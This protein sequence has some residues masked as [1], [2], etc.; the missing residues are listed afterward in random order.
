MRSNSRLSA[1]DLPEV[2]ATSQ[3][4]TSALGEESLRLRSTTKTKS[5]P[6]EPG[7][8]ESGFFDSSSSEGGSLKRERTDG[9]DFACS[10]D[11][12]NTSG[13]QGEITSSQ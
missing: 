10:G 1:L 4:L 8:R 13:I 9:M 5:K 7:A 2:H 6:R 12:G 11:M 3:H